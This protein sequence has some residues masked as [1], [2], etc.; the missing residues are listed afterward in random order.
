LNKPDRRKPGRALSPE[1]RQAM[2]DAALKLM[3]GRGATVITTRGVAAAAGTTERTLFK[4]FGSKDGLLKA[5]VQAAAIGAIDPAALTGLHDPEPMTIP[6]FV[7]WHRAFLLNRKASAEA[8]PETCRILFRELFGDTAF[9][10]MTAP[11]WRAQMFGAMAGQF[12]R[13]TKEGIVSGRIDAVTLAGIFYSIT[14]G[15]LATRFVLTPEAAWADEADAERIA[16]AFGVV[17]EG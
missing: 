12:E 17:L 11:D 3:S 2:I 7:D 4:H 13:M 15:Y 14:L 6:A 9:H 5:A 10:E 1:L 16:A 8:A